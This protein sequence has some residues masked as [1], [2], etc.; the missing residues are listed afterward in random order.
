[1]AEWRERSPI[2][3][4]Q[5][6]AL[7][8]GLLHEDEVKAIETEVEVQLR[9]D[10]AACEQAMRDS[11]EPPDHF[12]HRVR[13][14]QSD[15]QAVRDALSDYASTEPERSWWQEEQP[16]SLLIDEA[17]TIWSAI[18]ERDDWAPLEE[19][20]AAIRQLGQALGPAPVPSGHVG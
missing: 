17:E 11:A 14:G 3:R 9:N 15:D 2:A 5:R 7:D 10:V 16:V 19:K 12:F 20:I 1:M 8:N 4:F 18:A 6:W 13:A